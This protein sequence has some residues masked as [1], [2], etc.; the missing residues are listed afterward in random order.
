MTRPSG[1]TKR[2]SRVP[3]YPTT[4]TSGADFRT[5]ASAFAISAVAAG[6]VADC[7]AGSFTTATRGG[8]TPP[9]PYCCS[10][11]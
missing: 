1:D 3:G 2:A 4:R 10:S 6:A 7:P 8:D 9:L 11:A 5:A